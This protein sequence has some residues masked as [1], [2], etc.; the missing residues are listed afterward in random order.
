[1]QAQGSNSIKER[2]AEQENKE[3]NLQR[4]QRRLWHHYQWHYLS[5]SRALLKAP[6]LSRLSWEITKGKL[7]LESSSSNSR[8]KRERELTRWITMT[9]G[10]CYCWGHLE[11][12]A[13][14]NRCCRGLILR[15]DLPIHFYTDAPI[16]KA[17]GVLSSFILQV[18][19]WEE[20]RT[21][22]AGR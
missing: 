22:S 16:Q 5:L 13:Q 11:L 18:F 15:E 14:S 7:N 4:N 19:L 6:R 9:R 17:W 8:E 20:T 3:C 1:M 2:E 21:I 10:A 12:F